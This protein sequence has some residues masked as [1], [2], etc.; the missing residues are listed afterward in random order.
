MK[1]LLKKKNLDQDVNSK[2]HERVYS[3]F[4][5]LTPDHDSKLEDT[6]SATTSKVEEYANNKFDQLHSKVNSTAEL[7]L[8]VVDSAAS[9]KL[10]TTFF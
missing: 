7:T 9:S 2:V 10:D 8:A 3:T 5:L 4:Q 6:I 1:D